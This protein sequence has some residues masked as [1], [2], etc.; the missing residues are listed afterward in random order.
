MIFLGHCGIPKSMSNSWHTRNSIE[1]R[2]AMADAGTEKAHFEGERPYSNDGLHSHLMRMSDGTVVQTEIDGGHLHANIRG[3]NLDGAHTHIL[4]LPD[5][6]L[7]ETRTD[8][9][10]RHPYGPGGAYDG[11]HSHI[12]D[13]PDG[14]MM[15]TQIDGSH[16]HYY[17]QEDLEV[18]A[19]NLP[20]EAGP[21]TIDHAGKWTTTFVDAPPRLPATNSVHYDTDETLNKA[22]E[23]V[24]D[25]NATKEQS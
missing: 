10:H 22:A 9:I 18:I 6:T 13:L 16:Y 23:V 1:K 8:G 2:A 24:A 14:T 3:E 7:I 12:V 4:K 21:V 5:G 11:V 17:T 25:L 15:E 20:A 19:K